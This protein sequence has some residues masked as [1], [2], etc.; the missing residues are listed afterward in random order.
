MIYILDRI[1]LELE[2]AMYGKPDGR[3]QKIVISDRFI[4]NDPRNCNLFIN[5]SAIISNSDALKLNVEH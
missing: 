1:K 4:S 2:G 3:A 5:N